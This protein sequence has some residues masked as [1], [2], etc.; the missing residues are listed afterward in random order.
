[1]YFT[2][3]GVGEKRYNGWLKELRKLCDLTKVLP[4]DI[5]AAPKEG[6]GRCAGFK[7]LIDQMVVLVCG[8]VTVIL[9]APYC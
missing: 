6:V 7:K 2:F 8:Y 5:K 9:F 4:A 1:M 3:L